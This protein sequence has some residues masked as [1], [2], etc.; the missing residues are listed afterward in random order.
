MAEP[1]SQQ[2]SKPTSQQ[3]SKPA[4]QQA[5]KPASQP[6]SNQASK[7]ASQQASQQASW[8]ASLVVLGSFWSSPWHLLLPCVVINAFSVTRQPGLSA[9]I[10][11]A[12]G[13]TAYKGI[14][15]KGTEE[16]L[17][18][19]VCRLLDV[20][21]GALLPTETHQ[22]KGLVD[23]L[24]AALSQHYETKKP[25][26]AVA[27]DLDALKA[28]Y[29]FLDRL[30]NKITCVLDKAEDKCVVHLDYADKVE[31][32]NA[33]DVGTAVRVTVKGR[34][35]M[36]DSISQEFGDHGVEMP[37]DEPQWL[38]ALFG[39]AKQLVAT[40]QKRKSE[41]MSPSPKEGNPFQTKSSVM[42]GA[43]L[44]QKI[45]RARSDPNSPL[46]S[47]SSG[48]AASSEQRKSRSV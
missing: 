3:A 37:S 7:P 12:L 5:S 38:G 16:E 33:L 44:R 14:H 46:R 23:T 28:G 19:W 29:Y 40:P 42:L 21:K 17:M 2:A 8:E 43:A 41:S 35:T 47:K 22:V 11:E 4:S 25:V 10:L 13:S 18:Y 1:T 45:K 24:V 15:E 36:I 9:K 26:G 20:R 39:E 31:I 27:P 48:A 6:A 30:E 32:L 34:V